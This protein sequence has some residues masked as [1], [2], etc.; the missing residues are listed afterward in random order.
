MKDTY[1][2]YQ[3]LHTIIRHQELKVLR[4]YEP[5]LDLEV[6]LWLLYN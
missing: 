4:L 6:D 3:H 5:I 2:V 1:L